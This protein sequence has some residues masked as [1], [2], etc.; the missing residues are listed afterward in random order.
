M[1]DFLSALLP[2]PCFSLRLK[3]ISP[4]PLS[5]P[6]ARCA[7]LLPASPSPA[8][9]PS[10][11]QDLRRFAFRVG[12]ISV[13][14]SASA[15]P[16]SL[17][18]HR[19]A[20]GI[21]DHSAQGLGLCPLQAQLRHEAGKRAVDGDAAASTSNLRQSSASVDIRPRRH[22]PPSRSG[23]APSKSSREYLAW[24]SAPNLYSDPFHC[25]R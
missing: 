3:L 21:T 16:R 20:Q 24:L 5:H 6:P 10:P 1:Q 8:C 2:L 13:F 14:S 23:D 18:S 17:Y 19:C 7:P 9:S 4:H 22:I 11:R 12:A 15:H 25:G